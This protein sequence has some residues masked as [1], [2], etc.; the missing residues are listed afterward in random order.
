M[1]PLL[2]SFFCHVWALALCGFL[3]T[4]V[5]SKGAACTMNEMYLEVVQ[6]SWLPSLSV[7]VED[8]HTFLRFTL[9][10]H[11]ANYVLLLQDVCPV[12]MFFGTSL[13]GSYVLALGQRLRSF[14][15]SH[16]DVSLA[17]GSSCDSA[18]GVWIFPI[19][20]RVVGP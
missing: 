12:L 5:H 13:L 19:A 10:W 9:W 18:C 2:G 20:Q 8:V 7:V 6:D 1:L 4:A 11:I 3:F 16:T 14:M 17:L 15:T